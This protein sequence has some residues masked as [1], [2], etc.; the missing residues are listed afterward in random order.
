MKA[1]APR[2]WPAVLAFVAGLALSFA[3]SAA[4]PNFPTLTGRVVDQAN[5]LS[6]QIRADLTTKLEAL[7]SK[8]SR[9]LVVVTVPSLQGLEIEDYGYQLGRAWGIG[10]KGR[11]TGALLIVAPNERRVRV[12]VGYGLESVL[13]DALSN[14]ILQEQVL[15][16]LR[17]GD[18]PGGVVAGTDALIAQLSLPDDQAKARVAAA[19]QPP[20]EAPNPFPLVL[21]G[22]LVLWV[23]FGLIG[24]IGGRKGHRADLWLL[25]LL[26]F[27]GGGMRGG[28]GGGGG[29]GFSGGGGSFGGGGASGRW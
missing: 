23:V 9:Q 3:V 11:D 16:K 19:A 22:L 25:P 7:E 13:T 12:E 26:L 8:T 17:A 10:E 24:T 1:F 27:A 18:E 6:P 15:P 21:V 4:T 29:G 5:I 14:A 28:M 20:A 2:L